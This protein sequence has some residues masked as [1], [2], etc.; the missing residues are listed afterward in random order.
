MENWLSA[1]RKR[2]WALVVL[3]VASSWY[4]FALD[5]PKRIDNSASRLPDGTWELGRRSLVISH[6]ADPLTAIVNQ[7][8]FRLT[9]AARPAIAEQSGPARLFST[10]H[11]PWDAAFMIGIDHGDVVV[12]LPCGGVASDVDTEWRVPLNSTG[13]VELALRFEGGMTDKGFYL[14]VANNAW[15]QLRNTCPSGTSPRLPNALDHLALGNVYSGHRP[16]VGRIH[17]LELVSGERTVD[18]LR[19]L[20]WETANILALA[21]AP[22][23]A[24]ERLRHRVPFYVVAL[25]ELR[26]ARLS[27]RGAAFVTR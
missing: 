9:V 10:G 21:R 15:M 7:G 4:P 27:S 5:I 14:Q 17:T 22:L 1:A 25:P 20:P 16:F 8:P 26:C 23:R 11:S 18:L 12:R 2:F 6:T 13:D 24:F 19:A 3:I